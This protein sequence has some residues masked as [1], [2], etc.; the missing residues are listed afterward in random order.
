MADAIVGPLLSKLQ[1][2]AVTEGKALAAVREVAFAAEDAI[3]H[4]FLQVDLSRFGHNWRQ[5]AAMFF[6]NFGTQI[7][8]R[9]ILS[10]K[11][12]SMNM[13]LEDIVDNSAKYH[14][15]GES[16]KVITWR[17]SRAIPLVRQNW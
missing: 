5:A 9:Y 13:R 16:T 14:N 17:A 7:R 15:D 8:V 1:A 11:I 12:K 2:V 4:F 10:Q 3:D 6:S